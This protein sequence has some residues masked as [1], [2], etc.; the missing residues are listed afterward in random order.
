MRYRF[1]LVP[2]A[3]IVVSAPA[4]A[5]TYLTVEQAQALMCPGATLTRDFRTLTG[6][7]VDAIE[8]AS[9][10]N[11]RRRELRAWRVSTGGWFILDDVV[12][13]HEFITFALSLGPD[14]AVRAVEILDYREAYGSEI[15]IPAWR[16]QF[17]G[18]RHGARLK[19]GDDV[20][21][22]SGATL[23]CRHMADGVKRLL[24][25]HAIVLAPV[26]R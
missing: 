7:Q 6:A 26:P 20:K 10:V 24:A 8:E 13:K 17:T 2:L 21:N 3:S 9:G 15:R 25:T 16:A 18:K 23:S 22:I 12:G 11:V 5:A 1:A 19:L 14:G 4:L